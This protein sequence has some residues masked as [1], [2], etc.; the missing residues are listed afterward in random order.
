MELSAPILIHKFEESQTEV[1]EMALL[2]FSTT[3]GKYLT[4]LLTEDNGLYLCGWLDNLR[5]EVEL[6]GILQGAVR[7]F[8]E[9]YAYTILLIEGY[10]D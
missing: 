5:P 7:W 6:L 4:F 10:K 1:A 8:T 3:Y 9:H 2:V